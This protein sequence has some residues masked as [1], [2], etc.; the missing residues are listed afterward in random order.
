MY[1]LAHWQGSY[2]W[3]PLGQTFIQVSGNG[4]GTHV[5]VMPAIHKRVSSP[6]PILTFWL[7]VVENT[8]PALTLA[9]SPAYSTLLLLS[10]SFC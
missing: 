10:N 4:L 3:Q 9:R 5:M 6:N 8:S 1:N 2:K 7:T